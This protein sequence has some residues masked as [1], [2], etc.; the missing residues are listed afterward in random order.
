M[1]PPLNI[2]LELL[3]A[4]LFALGAV[5]GSLVNLAVYQLAWHARAISPWS[6][7]L[8]AAPPRMPWD[9]L[10]V[11]G[12]LT[13]R[14][15]APLHGSGYWLRP[16]ALELLLG[17]SF[18][19]LYYWEVVRQG[20]LPPGVK[21]PVPGAWMGMSNVD[22]PLVL[23]LTFAAHAV[24]LSVMLAVSLIDIDEKII[25]DTLTLPGTLAALLVAGCY[26]WALMPE[27]VWQLPQGLG[28]DFLRLNAP[29]DWPAMLG[30]APQIS[31]LLMALGCWW[32]WCIGLMPRRWI[33][34]RGWRQ[35]WIWFW[36]RLLGSRETWR[37][38]WLGIAGSL[39]IATAWYGADEAHWSGLLSGLVGMAGG[40]AIVWLVRVV[41]SAALG[42]EAMGFGDV[43]LMAMIGALL[44]WQSALLTFF[45]APFAG[46]LLGVA[47]VLMRED[48]EIPFGPFL[49]LGALGVIVGWKTIWPAVAPIFGMGTL[50]PAAFACCLVLMGAMLGAW[51][52]FREVVL[53]AE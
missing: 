48:Q 45:L 21:F 27:S 22:M 46:L 53:R 12:W 18:A 35:A 3:L 36:A 28:V 15:E 32:L 8:P 30:G 50:V 37:L 29:Q 7:K 49:C 20:L 52:W 39:V 19:G 31:S 1:N 38:L 40:G 42:R 25:P 9:R 16:L 51:R 43:T 34:R 13:L 11:L 10:P 44:G 23:H 14:R 2:S 33:L 17:I 41:G 5:A 24:L 6:A 47:K 4:G 26:P